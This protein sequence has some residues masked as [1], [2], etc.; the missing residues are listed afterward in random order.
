MVNNIFSLLSPVT[1]AQLVIK[2]SVFYGTRKFITELKK[3]A[4]RCFPGTLI[5]RYVTSDSHG[6]GYEDYCRLGF[7]T[8]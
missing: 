3:T 7:D 2:F 1:A 8:V 5:Q 4:A 6:D